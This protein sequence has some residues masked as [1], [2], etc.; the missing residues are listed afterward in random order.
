MNIQLNKEIE[1]FRKVIF[2]L[3]SC[4]RFK[5]SSILLSNINKVSI[6]LVKVW[7]PEFTLFSFSSVVHFRFYFCIRFDIIINLIIF[8]KKICY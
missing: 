1:Y 7:I 6:L 2:R 4:N 3:G 8:S 5:I